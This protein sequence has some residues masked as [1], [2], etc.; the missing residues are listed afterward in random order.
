MAEVSKLLPVVYERDVNM[1]LM[2]MFF[3]RTRELSNQTRATID[4]DK[5][6][7]IIAPYV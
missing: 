6:S 3:S 2:D 5:K 1:F 7:K 4:Y